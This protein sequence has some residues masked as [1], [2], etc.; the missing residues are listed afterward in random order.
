MAPYPVHGCTDIT[1]FGLLGHA[2]EMAQASKVTLAIEAQ[3]V[4]IMAE[5]LEHA[6]MGLV[7]AGSYANRNF[8]A[9]SVRQRSHID[10][11]L[12]DVIADA[13][14]SGGLLL[15]LPIDLASRAIDDLHAVGMTDSAIIGY[16]LDR[17]KGLIE[18][19]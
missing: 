19:R 14:T 13:Q 8:C 12:L 16:V 5:V 1:G 15:S 9:S 7:P 10:P 2:L 4:P 6:G 3:T 11:I 18:L 17:S